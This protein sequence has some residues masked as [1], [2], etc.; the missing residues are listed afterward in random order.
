MSWKACQLIPNATVSSRVVPLTPGIWL[1]AFVFVAF[2]AA[3]LRQKP[4]MVVNAADV[5]GSDCGAKINTADAIMDTHAGTIRVT[6]TCGLFWSTPVTLS[7]DHNLELVEAGTYVFEG[8]LVK[9]RNQIS[10]L[11]PST[12]LQLAPQQSYP[13]RGIAG[14]RLTDQNDKLWAAS[15][16][17]VKNVVLDGNYRLLR[18]CPNE[19]QCAVGV[20]IGGS[21]TSASSEI[22]ISD[23][24]FSGWRGVNVRFGHYSHPPAEIKIVRNT[25]KDCVSQCIESTGF[26]TNVEITENKFLGWGMQCPAN[27]DAIF[28]YPNLP[29]SIAFD[30]RGLKIVGNTFTN[31]YRATKFATEL[32]G[33]SDS[34]QRFTDVN[35]TGNVH[36]NR[37]AG[38]GGSGFSAT[39]LN[40]VIN[41]NIWSNGCG[42]QRC[43]IELTGAN[44]LISQNHIENGT[45]TIGGNDEPDKPFTATNDVVDQ[46]VISIAAQHGKAII[47]G[48]GSGMAA[49]RNTI[50]LNGSSGSCDAIIVGIRGGRFGTATTVSIKGNH[51]EGDSSSSSPCTGIRIAN[52]PEHPGSGLVVEDNTFARFSHGIYDSQKDSSLKD[53]TLKGNIFSQTLQP[54]DIEVIGAVVKQQNNTVH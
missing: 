19:L 24:V 45:I 47:V 17:W 6:Q 35:Y 53:I 36:D 54:I 39:I 16:V 21:G 12:V 51:L 9:G 37:H 27:C 14:I 13:A 29:R 10:G 2:S 3:T 15:S 31:V 34:G 41:G 46:N 22:Q 28:M 32:F 44:V 50:S 48:S 52:S 23:V 43:G 42:G 1:A 25:F 20:M 4:A 18:E 33:G 11:G 30:Q 40:G 38:G 5:E 49:T 7:A 26:S 8:I